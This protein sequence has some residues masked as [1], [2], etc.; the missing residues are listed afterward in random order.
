VP[1]EIFDIPVQS[2]FVRVRVVAL[3][4]GKSAGAFSYLQGIRSGVLQKLV[5]WENSDAVLGYKRN[6]HR[7]CQMLANAV[8]GDIDAVISPPSKMAWQAE[9]YRKEILA[10]NSRGVDLTALMTKSGDAR[11]G[12]GAT[13]EQ[14]LAELEYR[15]CGQEPNF[16]RIV[17]VDDTFNEGKT[18]AA[19]LS[20]L[21]QHGVSDQCT[22]VVACPLWLDTIVQAPVSSA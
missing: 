9:P 3:R 22:F 10:K 2:P 21:R 4:K 1:D 8:S 17:I 18:A 6:L 14:I 20:K 13:F 5:N 12:T 15:P 7:Y 11:S 16:Q 19:V